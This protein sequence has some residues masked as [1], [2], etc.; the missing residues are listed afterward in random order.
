[1][2]NDYKIRQAEFQDAK[3]IY[4]V[5]LAAFEE[6]RHYYTPEGFAD[7]VMSEQVAMERMK[8]MTLYVAIEQ[9]ETV[10]GTIGWQKVSEKE[11]HIRGMAV[12]PKRQ[13]KNSLARDL[14][15]A[16]EEDA[17][18]HGCK[19]LTLDTTA[20]LKRAQNF[21]RKHEFNETGITGDYFGSKIFEYRKNLY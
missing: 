17:Q 19:F 3:S 20:S 5:I 2:K 16:V 21:Y 15:Q 13:G 4:K 11:G 10:I 1:M 6:Y 12:Q 9:N 18:L 14:L 8:E 7:T